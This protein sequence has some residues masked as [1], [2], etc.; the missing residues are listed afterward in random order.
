MNTSGAKGQPAFGSSDALT[1]Q[2]T[3][4][5][6]RAKKLKALMAAATA[7]TGGETSGAAGDGFGG[8]SED[9]KEGEELDDDDEEEEEE[10]SNFGGRNGGV[11][12]GSQSAAVNALASVKR[13]LGATT[14]GGS[15]AAKA[16]RKLTRRVAPDR[17]I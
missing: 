1:S 9:G 8:G 17:G 7:H 12:G 2:A 15:D 10:S 14:G 16:F 4:L 11:E 3:A 5:A 6:G 13:G